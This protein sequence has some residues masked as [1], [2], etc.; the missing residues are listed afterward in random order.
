MTPELKAELL[1]ALQLGLEDIM[2]HS[3]RIRI[4]DDEAYELVS[5]AIEKLEA[6]E[7]E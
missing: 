7:T 1:E 3:T 6:L 5:V 2:R 4:Q